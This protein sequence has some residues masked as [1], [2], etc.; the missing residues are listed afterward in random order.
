MSIQRLR[1]IATDRRPEVAALAIQLALMQGDWQPFATELL[2]ADRMR[3]PWRPTPELARQVLLAQPA[4]VT[5]LRD[6]M[7][8]AFGADAQRLVDILAGISRAQLDKDGLGGLLGGLDAD[9]LALRVLSAFELTELT[10]N[11]SGY[12][13][14]APIRATIGQL[15][16]QHNAGRLQ[17]L[18]IS[19]PIWERTARPS[20]KAGP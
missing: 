7:T 6:A 13:P 9:N 20:V 5:G 18:P 14:H 3:A 16:Q 11:D 4:A 8:A 17:P 19:D 10:G 12:L 1:D 15:R 2:T